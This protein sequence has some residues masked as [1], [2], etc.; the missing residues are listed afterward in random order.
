MLLGPVYILRRV[1]LLHQLLVCVQGASRH[2]WCNSGPRSWSGRD[3]GAMSKQQNTNSSNTRS[4]PPHTVIRL[5]CCRSPP[6]TIV[7]VVVVVF[8]IVVLQQQQI[9]S[10]LWL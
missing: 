4:D 10:L 6:H 2:Q 3:K 5:D 1:L 8:V 9:C 7:F